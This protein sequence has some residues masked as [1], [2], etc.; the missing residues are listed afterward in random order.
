MKTNLRFLPVLTLVLFSVLQGCQKNDDD[1]EPNTDTELV[2]HSDDQTLLSGEM[3]AITNDVNIPLEASYTGTNQDS[4]ICS[5]SLV[6]DTVGSVKKITIN[7]DGSDCG[8]FHSR[9]GTVI[10]SMPSTVHWKDV[11]AEITV[12]YVNVKVT[13]LS[14]KKSITI[15]GSHKLTNVS[16]G[17]LLYLFI[18]QPSITHSIT[19][20][21]MTVTFDDGSQRQWQVS[22]QRVYTLANGGTITITGTH[23]EGAQTNVAEWGTDRYGVS[24]TSSITEPLII[25]G[26]CQYRLISG[27]IKHQR[28]SG[29]ATLSFGLNVQG[30]PVTCPAG[31][32][33][34]KLI[35]TGPAGNSLTYIGPY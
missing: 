29:S 18:G 2:T 24:F 31:S 15:N 14:D 23:Q 19:S 28:K 20:T 4:L 35:W 8:G 27:Q 1:P 16:G 25:S 32:Y 21:G 9:T 17:L 11:G 7:Y 3:E 10:I 12:T 33:Y 34:Y 13:R 5:A 30:V 26:A 6:Y 22:R